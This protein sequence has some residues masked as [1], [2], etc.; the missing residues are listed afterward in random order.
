M[1]DGSSSRNTKLDDAR[2]ARD[3]HDRIWELERR[4]DKQAATIEALFTLMKAQ[5]LSVAALTAEV[6]RIEAEKTAAAQKACARCGR[7]MG[8]RQASCV[9][10]GEPRVVESP[11]ELL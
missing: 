7:V 4:I 10:C 11:F 6:E 5:G 3:L 2:Y 9:Y 8:R 1:P